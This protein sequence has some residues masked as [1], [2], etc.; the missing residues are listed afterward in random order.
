MQEGEVGRSKMGGEIRADGE[1]E[2]EK[3]R[4]GRNG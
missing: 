3:I 1:D 2:G 4:E